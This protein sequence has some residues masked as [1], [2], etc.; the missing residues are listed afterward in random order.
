MTT[1]TFVAAGHIDESI[2]IEQ[3]IVAGSDVITR[4]QT[5][6]SGANVAALTVCGRITASAKLVKS[7]ATASD[8][9]QVPCAICIGDVA[10]AAADKVGPAYITGEFNLDA[11]VWDQSWTGDAQ[12]MGAFGDGP[13]VLRLL[14]DAVGVV[15]VTGDTALNATHQLVLVDATADDVVITLPT[16]A[17][18]FDGEVGRVYTVEKTDG[19]V[20]IVTV[21]ANASETVGGTLTQ[22][23]TS[24]YESITI[25]SDGTGW[26]LV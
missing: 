26:N 25:R 18:A 9:S 7:V 15:T 11:L 23:L 6:A 3:V 17:S 5:F 20:N 24:R 12:K 1:Q 16:A 22:V 4:P 2:G 14:R 8:G 13:I 19:S 10:S 21:D